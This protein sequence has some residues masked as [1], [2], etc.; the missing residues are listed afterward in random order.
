MFK[1]DG[2]LTIRKAA[3]CKTSLSS[4]RAGFGHQGENG[5]RWELLTTDFTDLHGWRA[6][7]PVLFVFFIRDHP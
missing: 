2:P 4:C 7:F 3:E 1:K 5:R 6:A